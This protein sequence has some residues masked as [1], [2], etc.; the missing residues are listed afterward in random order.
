MNDDSDLYPNRGREGRPVSRRRFLAGSTALGAAATAGCSGD[1]GAG[2]ATDAPTATPRSGDAVLVFNTGDA[3]VSV[4]DA[5][6]VEVV[7]TTPIGVT[8]SFPANQH[9]RTLVDSANDSVWVNVGR[10]V[11][12]LGAHRLEERARVETGSGANWQELTPDGEAVVVS[13]REPAHTQYRVDADPDSDRFG[14][15]TAEVDRTDEGGRGDNE[16][17]GP[18][19]VTVHPDGQYAFVPDLYGDTLTVL[20]VERFEVATQVDV[21]PVDGGAPQPWMGT[22]D[23][24]GERLLVEH[25][26][27]VETVWDVSDPTAPEEIARFTSADGLGAGPLTSEISAD[28]STGYVFTRGSEDVTVVDLEALE[29]TGRIDLGGAAFTGTWDPAHEALYVPVRGED[30]VRVIDHAAGQVTATLAV[31]SRPY[32]ATATR[33]VPDPE[34]PGTATAAASRL[35]LDDAGTTYCIGECACGHEL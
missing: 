17:P 27:D 15:V 14:E 34:S 6:S 28:G 24:Q 26:R 4:V 9:A 1:G 3:T 2:E 35:G 29:V 11:R 31:G 23:P 21:A 10:G 18:C 19:D 13:A 7:E 30:V 20:D 25:R 8:S 12:A 22:V 16:G 5:G 33:V 32:G